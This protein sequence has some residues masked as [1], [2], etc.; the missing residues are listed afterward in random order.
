MPFVGRPVVVG[1]AFRS[2]YGGPMPPDPVFAF[3]S[4]VWL[5]AGVMVRLKRGNEQEQAESSAVRV[6]GRPE[7]VLSWIGLL[8]ASLAL[9]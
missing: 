1:W 2:Y 4:L 8:R 7:Y 9:L 6:G 5:A 3:G